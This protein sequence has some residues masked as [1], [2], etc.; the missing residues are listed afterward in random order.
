MTTSDRENPC[1]SCGKKCR[2]ENHCE[3]KRA[4]LL[5]AERWL[6]GLTYDGLQK[7]MR[8]EARK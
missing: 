4:W 7:E 8:H 3:K 2:E 6:H 1:R 5:K